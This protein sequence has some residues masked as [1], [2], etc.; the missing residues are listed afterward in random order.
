MSFCQLPNLTTA[1]LLAL[2]ACSATPAQTLDSAPQPGRPTPNEQPAPVRRWS[3]E[4]NLLWPIFP[5]NIYSAKVLRTLYSKGRTAG[6]AYVGLLH[7]PYE[8]RAEE[9]RFS[10]SALL[11]GYRQYV[12]KG[13]NAEWYNA[14]GP[15]RLEGSVVDGRS[16][17]STDYEVGVLVGYTVRFNEQRKLPLY[18][19]LQ[20]LGFSYVA[21]QSNRH[22]IVGQTAETPIYVGAVQVG[23]RF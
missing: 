13:L 4:A 3:V 2:A 20:P 18:V 7:R 8:F 23:V 17:R 19:N 12:W 6:E 9:G 22:P 5:G 11:F 21:Y 10:N 14:I 16:Y 1:V 15:G